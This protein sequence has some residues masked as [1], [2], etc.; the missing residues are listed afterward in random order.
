VYFSNVQPGAY[1]IAVAYDGTTPEYEEHPVRYDA[2]FVKLDKATQGD[3]GG[4]YGKDGYVLCNYKGEQSDEKD[5]PSYVTRGERAE[6]ILNIWHDEKALPSYV[7]SLVYFRAFPKS[8]VPDQQMWA[9]ETADKRALAPSMC[10]GSSRKATGY[11]NG[12]TMSLTIGID[13]THEYQVALY[14]VDWGS[15]GLRQ[16]VEMMDAATLNLIAPVKLVNDFS[17]GVYL[18]YK[19][20]KSVKFRF[21]KIHGDIVSI[22]GIFFDSAIPQHT[23]HSPR[24]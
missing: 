5:R 24:G 13:G 12:Q 6:V 15:K 17:G 1:D 11:S 14:F 21:N 2:Q 3:W 4:V 20:N 22:S 9:A 10:N 19:Y 7:T 8:G 18:V 16:V 23:K